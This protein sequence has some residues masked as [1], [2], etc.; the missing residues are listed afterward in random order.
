MQPSLL[1][2]AVAFTPLQPPIVSRPRTPAPTCNTELPEQYGEGAMRNI[3]RIGPS[4]KRQA[5]IDKLMSKMRLRGSVSDSSSLVEAEGFA[6]KAPQAPPPS[7]P[8]M[9]VEMPDLSS[10]D[11]ADGGDERAEVDDEDLSAEA[12]FL[13]A[14]EEA[15]NARAVTA[16]NAEAMSDAKKT[17]GIGGNWNP[18]QAKDVEK[19]KPIGAGTWGVFER[20]ADI[21]KAYGGG[22]QIGAG[23]YQ[24]TE[25]EIAAKRAESERRLREYRKGTGA[26]LELQEAHRSEILEA[27]KEARQLMRFGATKAALIELDKVKPWC[28]ASTELGSETLLEWSMAVIADPDADSDEAKPTLKILTAKAPLPRV[29]KTAQQLMFQEAAESFLKVEGTAGDEFAKIA[30]GGLKAV[31]VRACACVCVG[32]RI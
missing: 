31:G 7:P 10:L 29:K 16:P 1:L 6:S 32:A 11:G 9:V 3:N 8:P 28:C 19:H 14:K 13:R 25:E 5:E 24:I 23:G 17:T 2:A 22:R 18:A 20:P 12:K 21:S 27:T 15:T 26:D 4:S 30:R